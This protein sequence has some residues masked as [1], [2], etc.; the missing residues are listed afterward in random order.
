MGRPREHDEQTRIDLLDAA[1][2]IVASAGHEA[3]SVRA[4]AHAAGT[5]T[6][7]VYSVFGSKDGL[8]AG[9][10]QRAFELLAISITAHPWTDDPL[11]DLVEASVQV[12]RPMAVG[13]PSLFRLAFLRTAPDLELT[14][15]IASAASAA[16]AQLTGRFERLADVGGLADR[17]PGDAAML[18]NALCEG[19]AT[20]ELRGMRGLGPAP[21]AAW[22]DAIRSL[23]IGFRQ[24]AP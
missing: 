10:A 18:F 22:R 19:L 23:L 5:T 24:R 17:D 15:G 20:S 7:A 2:A 1:E 3:V 11:D 14:P 8:L 12:F 16:F 6:R 13:H 9:L 21:E 4:V